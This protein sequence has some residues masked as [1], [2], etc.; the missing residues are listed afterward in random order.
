MFGFNQQNKNKDVVLVMCPGWGATQPPVGI[1]YLKSFLEQ[2]GILAQCLDL[3]MELYES[4]AEKKYWELNY[5]EHFMIPETFAKDIL[6]GLRSFLRPWAERILSYKSRIVGFSLFMS[7]VNTAILLAKELKEI[8]P[9]VFIVAGGSEVSRIKKVVVGGEQNF[10]SLNPEL[11]S[12]FDLLVDGEGEHA[13]QELVQRVR[14]RSDLYA[15]DGAFFKKNGDLIVNKPRPSIQN[16]DIVPAPDY[17]DFSL[18]KYTRKALPLMTSRGCVNRCAF[19]ADSP[20]W[21]H[22]RQ[23]S[24]AKVFRDICF[25]VQKYG[26]RD[27]E[28]ADSIFNADAGRIEKICDLIN[29]SGIKIHWSAK[30]TIR[31]EMTPA[32]LAKMKKSGCTDLAYGIESGSPRVLL[33]MKKNLDLLEA[34]KV[35]QATHEAGIR[36]NCFFLIGFPTETEEDFNL[37]LDFVSRNAPYIWRFDQ[38][39]GCHIEED[40]YLGTHLDEYGVILKNDGWCSKNSTPDIRRKRLSRFRDFARQLHSHYQCELQQ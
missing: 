16:L 37:T 9:H 33:E 39:T 15:I 27:F 2:E 34:E 17:T 18:K 25:L 1:S 29:Q 32:L 36:A 40:S 5:P 10:A 26:I 11:L 7:N 38:I 31:R 23:Q 6:P 28:I 30:A 14:K 21:K 20:L 19:C 4:F 12:C 22:Y 13:L 24:A 3:N 35:L 8:D